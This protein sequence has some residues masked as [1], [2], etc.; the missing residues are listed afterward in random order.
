[1][2]ACRRSPEGAGKR[3]GELPAKAIGRSKKA[4]CLHN[5]AHEKPPHLSRAVQ[6]QQDARLGDMY[7]IQSKL[8]VTAGAALS[9][10]ASSDDGREIELL[11]YGFDKPDIDEIRGHPDKVLEAMDEFGRT[12]RYMMNA[13]RTKG[14]IVT[15]IIEDVKPDTMVELGGYVGYS[16][17]LF[18]DCL[19]RA[20]G[21]RYLSLER[22]PEFAA[23][24]NVMAELAGLR[25]FVRIIVARSDLSLQK[26][27]TTD[28][29]L[30][31]HY[32]MVSPGTVLV[33]DNVIFPGNPQYLDPKNQYRNREGDEKPAL[34]FV[35]NP[36]LI[37]ESKLIKSF[38]PTGEPDGVEITR[39][40]GV[41][42]GS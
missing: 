11:H 6:A 42:E 27:Y 21:K 26:L 12:K 33:G 32:G 37:Y 41:A 40:V 38:E 17:I 14:E 19:R 24:A 34:D 15:G 25:D 8:K 35:G 28:L 18:G 20:G 30:C 3:Q 2:P 39:C 13:G 5:P 9:H 36:N 29:K 31:E 10:R 7:S 16:A 23:I 4:G 22:N 1:M